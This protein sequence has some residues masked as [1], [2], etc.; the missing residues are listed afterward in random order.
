[1]V[2]GMNNATINKLNNVFFIILKISLFIFYL[3]II[4]VLILKSCRLAYSTTTCK[5]SIFF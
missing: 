2:R 5:D 1:M 4:N 3:F